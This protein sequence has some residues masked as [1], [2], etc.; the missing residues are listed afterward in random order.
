M[1]PPLRVVA[2]LAVVIV[3]IAAGFFAYSRARDTR[4]AQAQVAQEYRAAAGLVEVGEPVTNNALGDTVA[5]LAAR[6]LS[7]PSFN[8]GREAAALGRLSQSV[9]NAYHDLDAKGFRDLLESH[10]LELGE[11]P[12][13]EAG[14]AAYTERFE[15]L[16]SHVESSPSWPS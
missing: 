8:A 12:E 15:R 4:A 13:G 10:G 16:A 11:D 9:L 5:Q 1:S 2:V 3:C 6:Q 14:D 7:H